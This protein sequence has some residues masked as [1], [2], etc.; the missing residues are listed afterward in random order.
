V[1]RGHNYHLI[2]AGLV[3]GKGVPSSVVLVWELRKSVGSELA[4]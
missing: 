2:L 4:V 1:H 3:G